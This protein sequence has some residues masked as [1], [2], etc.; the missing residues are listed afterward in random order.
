[1]GRT[2]VLVTGSAGFLGGH[3][4]RYLK[5]QGYWVRAVD[6]VAPRYGD[7][8]CDE[9][10]WDCDLRLWSCAALA[11][12]NVQEV[13]A[14]SSDMGGIGHITDP[15]R[16][17]EILW[18][19]TMINFNTL[20]TARW[21]GVQRYLFTSSVCVYPMYRLGT[22]IVPPLKEEDV[23]PALPNE[24]YGWEKLQAEHLCRHYRH[25]GMETRIARLQNTFGPRGAW[26]GGREK[27]PAA[28][29]RKI[30]IAKLTGNPEVEIWGDGKQTRSL[31]Y[32]DDCIYGLHLL[33]QSDYS[34]PITLGP[35]RV[36]SIDEIVD[37][38][39][40]AAGIEIVKKY[41]EGPQGVRGRNFDHSRARNILGWEPRVSL[42]EG[43]RRT[44]L[45]VE[46]QVRNEM[47]HS[48]TPVPEFYDE[49][50]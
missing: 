50:P 45:W 4:C 8:D 43:L 30:A 6:W 36:A 10:D 12:R 41:V 38:I 35:D 16:Q 2:R 49:S 22:T 7:V 42:E 27:A 34:E 13:Y 40:D 37:I 26:K 1:M 21:W 14:L 23:Y 33:M 18:N 24:S 20:E 3:L 25:Y 5:K 15:Q 17:A 19:N 44:Y 31:M 32:A 9:S 47:R 29:S 11:T 39:A 46:E 48:Q 28:L